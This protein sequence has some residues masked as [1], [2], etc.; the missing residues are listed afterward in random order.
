ME[1]ALLIVLSFI[2]LL[3]FALLFYAFV[4]S[5]PSETKR[6]ESL[7]RPSDNKRRRSWFSEPWK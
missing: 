2:C 3:V 1:D 5:I 4:L 6:R 7:R